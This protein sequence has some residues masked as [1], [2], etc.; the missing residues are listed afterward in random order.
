MMGIEMPEHVEHII[1]AIKHSVASSWFFF[2]TY[3]IKFEIWLHKRGTGWENFI[4][5]FLY[6]MFMVPCIIIYSMK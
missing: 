2:S 3:N 6:F 4:K 5:C 1:S